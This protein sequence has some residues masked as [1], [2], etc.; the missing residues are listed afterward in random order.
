MEEIEVKR[1]ILRLS[2]LAEK[3]LRRGRTYRRG[4]IQRRVREALVLAE[5]ANV[6]NVPASRD[7]VT[8]V[9]LTVEEIQ[10][11]DSIARRRGVS[12]MTLINACLLASKNSA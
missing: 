10:R 7:C 3:Q 12:R 4:D 9:P 5:T 8:S 11:V 1:V 2:P 6:D